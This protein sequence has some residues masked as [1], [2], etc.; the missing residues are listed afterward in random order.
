MRIATA[1][2]YD[3]TIFNLQQ[4]QQ[5]LAESQVQLTS[6][7]RVNKASDD[8]TSAA[9]AERALAAAAR[10]EA[11]Q[12]SLDASRNVMTITESALGDAVELILDAINVFNFENYS[13]F[14]QCLCSPNYGVPNNQYI[15]TRSFQVGLRYRW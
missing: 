9:R 12:R 15:P 5:A 10:N 1:F 14:E 11:N 6:G 7:K 2:A 8:P 4:R 3:Q 13:G